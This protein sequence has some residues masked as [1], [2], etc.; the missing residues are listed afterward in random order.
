MIRAAFKT[1][2]FF[3]RACRA[4]TL[5]SSS[6]VRV[7]LQIGLRLSTMSV[8]RACNVFKSLTNKAR[9]KVAYSIFNISS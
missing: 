3:V 8:I 6:V 2:L 1:S 7:T 4:G 5:F 9:V